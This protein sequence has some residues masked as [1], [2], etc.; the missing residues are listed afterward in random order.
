M[1]QDG[2]IM[3]LRMTG[4]LLLGVVRIY[5]RKAKYLLDDCVGDMTEDQLV[6]N[7]N[8]ITLQGAGGVDINALIPD[9]DWILT[10]ISTWVSTRVKEMALVSMVV[11]VLDEIVEQARRAGSMTPSA[12]GSD[13]LGTNAPGFE[14]DETYADATCPIAMFDARPNT[15]TQST[16][17][18]TERE[19]EIANRMEKGIIRKES[20]PVDGDDVEEKVM[21]FKR[22][23]DKGSRRAAALFFFESLV[24]GTRD[25]VKLV[26]KTPFE[27]IEVRAKDK[28]WGTAKIVVLVLECQAL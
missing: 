26:Q 13:I 20:K 10:R 16:E 3:A 1:D 22:M 11:L 14:V 24:L 19:V 6:A 8:A 12:I 25:C 28:L 23:A 18:E 21:S 17:Q 27:N 2:E 7:K 9:M 15:Q 4:Q 5:S